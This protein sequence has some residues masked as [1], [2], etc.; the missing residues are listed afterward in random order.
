MCEFSAASSIATGVPFQAQSSMYNST[1]L[2]F[3][4]GVSAP[5]ASLV[6]EMIELIAPGRR[7]GKPPSACRS[8]VALLLRSS[9][10][11]GTGVSG[12]PRRRRRLGCAGP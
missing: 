9:V 6:P 12:R 3:R 5:F 11:C 8:W 10:G 2:G 1:M 4:R 7:P